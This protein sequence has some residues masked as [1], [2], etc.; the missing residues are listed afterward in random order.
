M[1]NVVDTVNR[2]MSRLGDMSARSSLI[3]DSGDSYV[4][5]QTRMVSS[6]KEIARVAQEMVRSSYL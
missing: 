5:Y 2:A 3:I 6:A 1:C 4:D